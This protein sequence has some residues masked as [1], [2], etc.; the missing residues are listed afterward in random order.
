METSSSI[1]HLKLVTG[2]ELICELVSELQDSFIVKNALSLMAKTMNDGTKYFA[3]KTYMVYQDTP[4]NVIMVFTDKVMS[5]AVPTQEMVTQY[6]NALSE[7]AAYLE[8][9]E[10]QQLEDDFKESLSLD[11]FLDE[12]NMKLNE[13]DIDSD[14]SGMTIN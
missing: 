7:M 3:F 9:D 11:D 10:S 13:G 4:T 2:E 12:M 6:A 1:K 5:I 8:E 14:I